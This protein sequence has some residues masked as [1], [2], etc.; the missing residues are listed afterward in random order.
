MAVLYTKRGGGCPDCRGAEDLLDTLGV[1]YELREVSGDQLKLIFD[2][3]SIAFPQL[4]LGDTW[5]GGYKRIVQVFSEPLLRPRD[6]RFVYDPEYPVLAELFSK[7]QASFWMTKEI[8]FAE[9]ADHFEEKLTPDER[10]FISTI[11]QFFAASDGIVN[12]SLAERVQE[13][14]VPE[15]RAFLT[16]QAY[17]ESVHAETY[18]KILEALFRDPSERRL[19]LEE[20]SKSPSIRSKNEWALKWIGPMHDFAEKIVAWTCVELIFFS[21]SFCA[22]F[23]IKRKGLLPNV[24]F[25]NELI[26]RDEGLHGEF[27]AELY[28]LIES[29]PDPLRVAEIVRSAVEA[30]VHFV[31]SALQAD[32]VGMKKE[33]L[34]DH[35]RYMGDRVMQ[36]LGLPKLYGVDS[37]YLDL[38]ERQSLQGV[39]N[40]F[41]KTVSEYARGQ[42]SHGEEFGGE[43]DL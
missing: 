31:N 35:V 30:E 18:A 26:S 41:E 2:T 29:K 11:I 6:Q 16:Y 4:K 40:F 12:E 27:S 3:G 37:P 22:L 38:C 39:T 32:V 17:N 20:A 25:S 7:A 43:G 28:R 19:M 33:F 15:A 8:S 34:A 10:R 5:V 13:L 42:V 21:S 9:D 24:C 23:W 14:Q 36:M 1:D